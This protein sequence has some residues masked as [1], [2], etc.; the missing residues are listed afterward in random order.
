MAP[1]TSDLSARMA[2]AHVERELGPGLLATARALQ[3]RLA[4]RG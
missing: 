1:A 4:S 2:R 3:E